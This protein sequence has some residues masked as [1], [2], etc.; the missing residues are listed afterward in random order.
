[1]TT[2]ES[3]RH[4]LDHLRQQR[5]QIDEQMARLVEAMAAGNEQFE[6]CRQEARKVARHMDDWRPPQTATPFPGDPFSLLFLGALS[7]EWAAQSRYRGALPDFGGFLLV[8]GGLNILIDPGRSTLSNLHAANIHPRTLD[9][10]IATHGH[11]DCVRDL[12]LLIMAAT[13]THVTTARRGRP[14]LHLLA[15]R[16]VLNGYPM[17]VNAVLQDPYFVA[18]DNIAVIQQRLS[19]F[20]TMNAPALNAFD[21]FVRLGGNFETLEIGRRYPLS[22]Q[23][24]IRTR[25]SFHRDTFGVDH[26]AALDIILWR[27]GRRV[28]RC[29][30][31]SDT[32]YRFELADLYAAEPDL[33][34]ID[35]LIANVKTLDVRPQPDGPLAGYTRRHLGWRGLVQLTRDLRERGLLTNSSLV[36][37]RAWGIET[38]TRLD[39]VDGVMTATPEKLGIYEEAFVNETGQAAVV[40]GRTWVALTGDPERRGAK[41]HHLRA[42]F[43]PKGAFQHFGGIWYCSEAMAE[44]IRIVRPAVENSTEL[45]LMTGETGTGKD[46]VAQAIHVESMRSGKLVK[47]NVAALKLKEL[48]LDMLVGHSRGAFTGATSDQDGWLTDAANGTLNIQE[49]AEMSLDDQ[50]QFLTILGERKYKRLGDRREYRLTAQVIATT[51][52]DVDALIAANRFKPELAFRFQRRA[53]MPPLR[54]R[55]E[56]IRAIVYGAHFDQPDRYPPL[57]EPCVA[58][59]MTYPWPGNVRQLLNVL[60]RLHHEGNPSLAAV[61]REI[62]VE[63]RNDAHSTL[64]VAAAPAPTLLPEEQALLDRIPTDRPVRRS[65]IEAGLPPANK[66]TTIGRLKRLM[67]RGMVRKVGSGPN[68]SYLRV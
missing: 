49:I 15:P 36:V 10:V 14:R 37:P 64:A 59:L 11:W 16:S 68:A 67:A 28:A 41:V 3:T 12:P 26:V 31:L 34:P 33:G 46:A 24:E 55:L 66:T 63:R 57:D 40:P 47:E 23:V 54:E 48:A 60:E 61:Q 22:D 13:D 50:T 58:L 52:G 27:D 44:V 38:V 35:I 43:P 29:V 9:Y 51:S 53:H 20:T 8:A 56:D 62:E 21:L 65:E 42:P 4:R 30:Y 19:Q 5:D 1:M 32:E 18:H 17:D 25:Q 2:H 6:I 39:P 7:G 45:L